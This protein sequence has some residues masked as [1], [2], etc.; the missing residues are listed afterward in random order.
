LTGRI[1][2]KYALAAISALSLMALAATAAG[3]QTE[4]PSVPPPEK[5][6]AYDGVI[7]LSV[8]VTDIQRRIFR[9][10]E[11]VPVS[12]GQD[13][14]LLYPEWVPGTHAPLGQNRLNRFAGLVV[15]ANNDR[16]AWTRD[17][18]H[19]APKAAESLTFW[20]VMSQS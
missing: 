20:P 8:D 5:D 18:H 14:V 19:R 3:A 10:H 15:T 17:P 2:L 13:L 12:G 7:G 9:V 4:C 6:R 16:V 1:S 11:T